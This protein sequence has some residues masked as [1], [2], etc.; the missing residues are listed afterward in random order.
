MWMSLIVGVPGVWN[1]PYIHPCLYTYISIHVDVPEGGGARGLEQVHILGY[2]SV[3]L[4]LSAF[5]FLLQINKIYD[6]HW[7]VQQRRK[8]SGRD[9]LLS[10]C[11]CNTGTKYAY[12][13]IVK[14]L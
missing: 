5:S 12:A 14:L 11:A 7:A 9:R 13:G 8:P 10:P 1:T 6:L 3:L 2:P 4:S